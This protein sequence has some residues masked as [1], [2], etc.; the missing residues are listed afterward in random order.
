[1]RDSEIVTFKVQF[2]SWMEDYPDYQTTVDMFQR[3]VIENHNNLKLAFC[4]EVS[5]LWVEWSF[6]LGCLQSQYSS[7]LLYE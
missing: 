2:Q 6:Q 5:L 3:N 1:V 4:I 7:K